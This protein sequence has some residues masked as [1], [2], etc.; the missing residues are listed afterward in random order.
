MYIIILYFH[1]ISVTIFSLYIFIDRTIIRTFIKQNIR[2]I[3]YKNSK[4]PMI[5]TSGII[6][7]SGLLLIFHSN[8]NILLF[9]KIICGITLIYAFFNCPFFMKK[10]ECEVK[11]FMYRFGVVILLIITIGLGLYI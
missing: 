6:I 4:I 10:E 11:K 9:V 1:I 7:M 3:F 8:M 5:F 2:E